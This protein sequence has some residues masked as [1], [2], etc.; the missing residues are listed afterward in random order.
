VE[1]GDGKTTLG[2]IRGRSEDNI[3][4]DLTGIGIV[5]TGFIWLWIGT[6]GE[7]V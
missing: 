7:V 2:R 1:E 6:S 5:W 3:Q 4:V